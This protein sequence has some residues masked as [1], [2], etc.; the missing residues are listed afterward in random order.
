MGVSKAKGAK[1]AYG[2]GREDNRVAL[3]RCTSKDLEV[4]PKTYRLGMFGQNRPANA[5]WSGQPENLNLDPSMQKTLEDMGM[6]LSKDPWTRTG[7]VAGVVGADLV[8]DSGR[9]LWWLL[10]APQAIGNVATEAAV[11]KLTLSIYGSEDLV[12]W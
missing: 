4:E 6:G 5:D 11:Q 8:Q 9:E 2:E 12:P 7:Q 10:N 3:K 1:E